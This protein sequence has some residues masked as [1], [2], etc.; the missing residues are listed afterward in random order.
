MSRLKNTINSEACTFSRLWTQAASLRYYFCFFAE[1]ISGTIKLA[2]KNI[3][4][5]QRRHELYGNRKSHKIFIHAYHSSKG[6][7]TNTLILLAILG[8]ASTR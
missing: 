1:G 7:S 8:E 2:T 3:V 4:T 6:D 5:I